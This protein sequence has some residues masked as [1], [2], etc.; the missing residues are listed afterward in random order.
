MKL[1]KNY[2]LRKIANTYVVLPLGFEASNFDGFVKLNDSGMML[3]KA[4]E[5]GADSDALVR[6]L[7]T[8]YDVSVV[9]AEK[10]VSAFLSTLRACGCF[11]E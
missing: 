11:E 9:Q 1:K 10:D 5:Q 3:W 7:T 8:E 2:V 6:I 4:L